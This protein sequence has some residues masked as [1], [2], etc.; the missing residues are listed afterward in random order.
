MLIF[1]LHFISSYNSLPNEGNFGYFTSTMENEKGQKQLNFYP[2]I[3]ETNFNSFPNL[4]K[5]ISDSDY[6]QVNMNSKETIESDNHYNDYSNLNFKYSQ[7]VSFF[8][9]QQNNFDINLYAI[10]NFTVEMTNIMKNQDLQ[11]KKI[12]SYS[13]TLF[14]KK[15][16]NQLLKP[17]QKI[18]F[19]FFIYPTKIGQSSKT[20]FIETDKG[21]FPYYITYTVHPCILPHITKKIPTIYQSVDKLHT[22]KFNLVI[23]TPLN[24]LS[25]VFDSSVFD[26]DQ[27]YITQ[28]ELILA[29]AEGIKVG[30]YQTF[31]YLHTSQSIV[32]IPMFLEIFPNEIRSLKEEIFIKTISIYDQPVSKPIEIFNPTDQVYEVKNIGFLGRVDPSITIRRDYV[33]C[34]KNQ[35]THIA[36]INVSSKN[37]FSFN[38]NLNIT[39]YN[40]ELNETKYIIVKIHACVLSG[41]LNIA[42]LKNQEDFTGTIS[43]KIR[44][45][46]A[47]PIVILGAYIDSTF[48]TIHE[49]EQMILKPGR[50]TNILF[51]SHQYEYQV[52]YRSVNLKIITN[53]TTCNIPLKKFIRAPIQV[54]L[55]DKQFK[56]NH[57]FHAYSIGKVYSTS[58]R[59]FTFRITNRNT[60]PFYLLDI[61]TS[62]NIRAELN[63]YT[64]NPFIQPGMSLDISVTI[65]FVIEGV[66]Q[67]IDNI[68]FMG[69]DNLFGQINVLWEPINGTFRIGTSLKHDQTYGATYHGDVRVQ[70]TYEHDV[71][72]RSLSI[73]IPTAYFSH[74]C[75][76]NV[77]KNTEYLVASI[78][79]TLDK[80]YFVTKGFFD[81]IDCNPS[82]QLQNQLWENLWSK[83]IH[84]DFVVTISLDKGFYYSQAIPM[85]ITSYTLPTT[86]LDF[87]T[88]HAGEIFLRTTTLSNYFNVPIEFKFHNI[89]QSLA[90]SITYKK[91]LILQPHSNYDFS[92]T[93]EG[94]KP[95]YYSL[96]I[97][98]TTNLTPPFVIPV[99]ATTEYPKIKFVDKNQNVVTSVDFSGGEDE[100]YTSDKWTKCIY[101]SNNSPGSL[102]L[103]NLQ[104]TPNNFIKF[105]A[106]QT[107]LLKKE[108]ISL[109]FDMYLWLYQNETDYS[110]LQFSVSAQNF[111]YTIPIHVNLSEATIRHIYSSLDRTQDIISFLSLLA[112]CT[113][114][115]FVLI[116]YL[117]FYKDLWKKTKRVERA[118]KHYSVNNYKTFGIQKSDENAAL[119][120]QWVHQNDPPLLP[121]SKLSIERMEQF[122]I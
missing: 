102:S 61:Q 5:I 87:S 51:I 45:S 66:S 39:L 56:Y 71:T 35:I 13:S 60:D 120:T 81:M 15:C 116:G 21:T 41:K 118:V 122:I 16:E 99:S 6:I 10:N 43:H 38:R 63:S 93:F 105:Y 44:N 74:D 121:A 37:T 20:V 100:L 101:I 29:P 53:A 27:S 112:P 18:T 113:S 68:Y 84:Y 98:V 59:K 55:L 3:S 108:T 2:I 46:F 91:S 58:K 9:Q 94:K 88:I 67:Y 85:S 26:A 76:L 57:S 65:D 64:F 33:Y 28:F 72:L 47:L 119:S 95:G 32:C 11:I 114:L 109:C 24:N 7:Y 25:M 77:S 36:D 90:Y 30:R 111:V 8:P 92:V 31:I 79:I 97:P 49:F 1:L 40:Q 17:N 106:N 78:S 42:S 82:F 23:D 80:K 96:E 89:K 34:F 50:D 19:S 12:F 73:N 104:I 107:N 54:D 117:W 4:Q 70:S 22:F 69:E 115:L 48:I 83:P 103:T 14:V 110:D 62:K 75:P 86:S 52:L